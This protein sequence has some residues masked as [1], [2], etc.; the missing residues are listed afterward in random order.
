MNETDPGGAKISSFVII[1]PFTA[2]P[3]V[4]FPIQKHCRS[5]VPGAHILLNNGASDS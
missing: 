4:P 3:L 2:F 1:L 5:T